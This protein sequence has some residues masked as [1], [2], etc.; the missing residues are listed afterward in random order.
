MKILKSLKD[1]TLLDRFLFSEFMEDPQ[2][3]EAVLEI[4]LGREIL[5]RYLPHTE[6]EQRNS[7]L[8]R[9][10]R[11]DVWGEDQQG[12][13]YDVEVQKKDTRNLSR[14]S[15]FYQGIIDGKM[16]KP[17]E[18]DFNHL[19]DSYIIIIAPFDPFGKGKYQYIFEMRC[20]NDPDIMLDDGAVRIFLNTHGTNPKEVSE[21][22]VE[23][24]DFM[25]HTNCRSQ[26]GYSSSRIQE[27][28]RRIERIKSNEEVGVRFMQAW[29]ERELD[30]REAREEGRLEQ[31]RELIQKKL[32]KGKSIPEIA[33]DLETDEETIQKLIDDI[34]AKA[35]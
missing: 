35:L 34:S 13:V 12:N 6:K 14:R 29:E 25:E 22:L 15:R 18:T 24:L 9:Y 28:Q 31:M 1:L 23:L 16:L 7:P 27:L 33:E 2:N 19:K 11:L 8:H 10:I 17:G 4:I 21:E 30:K 20:R 5:L 32:A 26:E 3:L